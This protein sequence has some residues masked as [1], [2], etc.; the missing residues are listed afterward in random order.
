MRTHYTHRHIKN[1]TNTHKLK[2]AFLDRDLT[3]LNH[4]EL[5]HDMGEIHTIHPVENLKYK[6]WQLDGA[7]HS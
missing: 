5:S 4:G 3:V 6:K 1:I 2:E 7:P